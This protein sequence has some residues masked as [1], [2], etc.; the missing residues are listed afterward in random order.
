[1]GA[2]TTAVEALRLGRN[3]AGVELEFFDVVEANVRLNMRPG[4]QSDLHQGDARELE[5]ILAPRMFD[6]VV[7][8][9]PYSGDQR[10]KGFSKNVKGSNTV[11]YDRDLPNLAHLKESKEYWDLIES[12]YRQCA[13]KMKP[14]A[15]FVVGVKDMMR[16]GR[17]FKLH[18]MLGDVLSQF[19][20][21]EGMVLLKHHP[22]TLFLNTYEKKTGIK[23]PLYQTILIFQKP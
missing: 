7:N 9:P 23:P 16:A 1:M 11:K 18:E 6:L 21:Y 17:P 13:K 19:L 10:E 14:G 22:T 2:G 12:V 15:K 4:L 5:K 3:P 8:N 20:T